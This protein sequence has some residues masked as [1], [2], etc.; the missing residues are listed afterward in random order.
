MKFPEGEIVRFGAVVIDG[1]SRI[2]DGRE[3]PTVS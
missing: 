2:P 1:F 3:A